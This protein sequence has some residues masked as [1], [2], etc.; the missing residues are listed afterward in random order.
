MLCAN[1]IY[2]QWNAEAP[3]EPSYATLVPAHF[4][5][6]LRRP[7]QIPLLLQVRLHVVSIPLKPTTLSPHTI[8]T[9]T[10]RSLKAFPIFPTEEVQHH[11][12]LLLL[13]KTARAY[14]DHATQECQARRALDLN[15]LPIAGHPV[16]ERGN[17]LGLRA[18]A[19][20]G[21]IDV[22]TF[23]FVAEWQ[24]ERALDEFLAARTT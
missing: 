24:G 10:Q 8:Q 21:E 11:L 12:L 17:A 7:I 23:D 13:R 4:H 16:P 5:L 19:G 3:L 2:E 6:Q 22:L 1:L 14:L 18:H 15:R 9:L 20:D